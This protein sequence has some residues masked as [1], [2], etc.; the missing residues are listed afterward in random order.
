VVPSARFTLE[1]ALLD[2]VGQQRGLPVASCLGGGPDLPEV[3]INA[4][5]LP[6]PLD[7][8]AAR[9]EALAARGFSA[10]NIKL[11]A[12][13]DDGFARELAALRA[14]RERLPL[15]FEIRL[16][17]NAAWPLDVARRR[18]DALAPV[19]PRYV[20]HPVAADVL[21]RLGVCAVP[22]A[23]DESLAS[24]ELV[25]PLLSSRGC[26]SFVLKQAILGGA[27]RARAL[28]LRAAERGVPSVVTHTW[29]APSPWRRPPSWP[30][31]CLDRT[32]PP[33]SL[34]TPGRAAGPL[35]M[36][37][38]DHDGLGYPRHR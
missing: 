38:T 5:L 6:D 17:P 13:D 15:P 35:L 4:L 23:A 2:L 36:R 22:W 27:L 31:P 33:G 9:A 34:P 29:M 20:Q 19:A 32:S 10:V 28:A 25:E 26:A 3:P 14:V 21:P 24:P 1:T 18:L 8:L 16:D 37:L 12:R 30:S 7:T 11:R